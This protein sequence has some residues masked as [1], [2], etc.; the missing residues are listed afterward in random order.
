MT[1]RSTAAAGRRH[2]TTPMPAGAER[3][4]QVIK[5]NKISVE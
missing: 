5:A 2:M 3:W 1:L 4:A